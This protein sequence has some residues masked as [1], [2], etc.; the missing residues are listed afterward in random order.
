MESDSPDG[1]GVTRSS[2]VIGGEAPSSPLQSEVDSEPNLATAEFREL[3]ELV[4]GFF[5]QA[6]VEGDRPPPPKFLARVNEEPPL[7]SASGRFAQYDRLKRV[8]EDMAAKVAHNAKDS[9][10]SSTILHKRRSAYRF[11]GD[12]QPRLLMSLLGASCAKTD[13]EIA[14]RTREHRSPVMSITVTGSLANGR[15]ALRRPEPSVTSR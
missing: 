5:P 1:A 13:R 8:Q 11:A 14:K 3:W 6:K 2:I 15:R 4:T 12:Q 9:K 7:P 10:K